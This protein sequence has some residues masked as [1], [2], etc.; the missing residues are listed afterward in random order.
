VAANIATRLIW[1]RRPSKLPTHCWSLPGQEWGWI[2]ACLTSGA[3][4]GFGGAY[5][6]IAKLGLSFEEM[7]NP[8]W[9]RKDPHLA[10]AFYGRRLNLYRKATPH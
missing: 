4:R 6:V 1:R 3:H 2:P 5:P 8:D 9:F 10:W 7:A